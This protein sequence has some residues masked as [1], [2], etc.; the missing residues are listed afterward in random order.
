[1]R[2][3]WKRPVV[4]VLALTGFAVA[5]LAPSSVADTVTTSST[6]TTTPPPPSGD[7]GC[8]SSGSSDQQQQPTTT[9]TTTTKTVPG[10]SSQD[11]TSWN[12]GASPN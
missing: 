4:F 10:N 8:C 11:P 2:C 5:S 6:T 3:G 7:S 1:M 9:T 12:Y